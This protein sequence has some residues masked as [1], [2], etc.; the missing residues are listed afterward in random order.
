[1]IPVTGP[2]K[3]IR[4]LTTLYS[5]AAMGMVPSNTTNVPSNGVSS[6]CTGPLMESKVKVRSI[7]PPPRS[8]VAVFDSVKFGF[9]PGSSPGMSTGAAACFEIRV[10]PG[11][12]AP[13]PVGA[14]QRQRLVRRHR[15]IVN[16]VGRDLMGDRGQ[17]IR[18]VLRRAENDVAQ[19]LA[20]LLAL[21]LAA[22]AHP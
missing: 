8:V 15:G 5:A 13:I 19:R 11:Q 12:D 21:H 20:D 16:V 2:S 14:C 7:M 4:L 17:F 18:R 3:E 22:G 9:R 10:K 6:S 1:M